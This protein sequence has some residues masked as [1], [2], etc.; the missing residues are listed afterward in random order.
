MATTIITETSAETEEVDSRIE[1]GSTVATTTRD[2]ETLIKETDPTQTQT[3]TIASTELFNDA[4]SDLVFLSVI[5]ND[6]M[7]EKCRGKIERMV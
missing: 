6:C 2:R 7:V 1:M 4:M 5:Y 3:A